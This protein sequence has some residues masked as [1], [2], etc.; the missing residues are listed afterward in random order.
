MN[1]TVFINIRPASPEDFKAA[2]ALEKEVFDLHHE[3]RPDFFRDND[4]PLTREGFLDK[5]E[6]CIY[7]LAEDEKGSIV[8]Q[9]VALIRGYKDHPVF[10]D[11]QWFEIDDISVASSARR[12]GVGKMLFEAMK[13]EAG[14]RGFDHIELC[15]WSFNKEARAFYE[16]L[17]MTSRIDRMEIEL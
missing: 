17:G 3:N 6:N 9:A 8:G 14:Q 2:A 5:L 11:R 10:R 13:R 12:M 16:S 4:A 1:K 15:V 7:L